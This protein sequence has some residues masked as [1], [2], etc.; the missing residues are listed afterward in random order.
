MP[1]KN[2]KSSP[3][4]TAFLLLL[5]VVCAK[6]LERFV[7]PEFYTF[8]FSN[9][10]HFVLPDLN[11]NIISR[12]SIS[13]ASA[14]TQGGMKEQSGGDMTIIGGGN[15]KFTIDIKKDANQ[16]A[17][18]SLYNTQPNL[19]VSDRFTSSTYTVDL[20]DYPNG[21]YIFNVEVGEKEYS[22]KVLY[23]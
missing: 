13:L 9:R 20:T 18:F 10:A 5:N 21:I 12:R 19:L 6:L 11:G 22:E 23:E 1:F 7:F 17:N 8:R 3:I 14:K 4:W 15:G 16:T 2:N